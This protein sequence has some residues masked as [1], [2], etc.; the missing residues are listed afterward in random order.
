M[1]RSFLLPSLVT[2]IALSGTALAQIATSTALTVSPSAVAQGQSARLSATVTPLSG[3]T[4]TGSVSFY[5]GSILLASAPLSAGVASVTESAGTLPPGTYSI[6]AQY[7]GNSADAPSISAPVTAYVQ[8][9]TSTTVSAANSILIVGQLAQI[10][11]TVSSTAGTPTG[12]VNFF[13]GSTLIGSAALNGGSATYSGSTTGIDP[14]VYPVT[15]RY[16]GSNAFAP[17]SSTVDIT[18]DAAFTA[19]PANAAI[20]PGATQQFAIAPTVGGTITWAVNGLPGGNASY[21]TISNSGLYTAPATTS[22]LTVHITASLGSDPRYPAPS[23]PVYVIPAGV[24]TATSN[25]QVA[26]YTINAPAG[27]SV[28]VNFGTTTSYGLNTWSVP[29]P[30]DGG[31]VTV[32]VAGML[33]D[34]LYNIQGVVTLPDGATFTDANNPFTTGEAVDASRTVPFT[35]TTVSGQTPQPGI[36]LIDAQVL[37]YAVDLDGNTIWA[38]PFTG[39][40]T[41]DVVRPIKLQPNGDFLSHIGGNDPLNPGT[42]LPGTIDIIQE[43]DLVGNV[44]RQVSL[45]TLQANLSAAGYNITL[46]AMHHDLTVNPTTGHW[47][48]LSNTLQTF[49]SVDGETGPQTVEGDIILDVDPGNNFAIDWVWNA[50]DYLDVN[51]HPFMFPDWTHSNAIIY[52]PTDHQLVVSVRHQNWILKLDY[53]DGGGSG[54]VLW[55]LGYQGD[56]SLIGGTSPQDWQYAQHGPNFTGSTSAGNFGLGVMD[57]GDDRVVPENFTCP[58]ALIQNVCLYSRGIVYQIDENA[59]TATLTTAIQSP[60]YSYFGG[61]SQMLPNGHLEYDFCS[62]NVNGTDE[63]YIVEYTPGSNPQLV[64]SLLSTAQTDYR[65]FRIGSLYPGVSWSAAALKFQ[66]AHATHPNKK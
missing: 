5:S 30:S 27:S 20:S 53:Q 2:L 49:Q 15:A 63:G 26:S 14:G 16:A 22:A 3:S 24:V 39:T 46:G 58:V 34:T 23:V 50:F 35:P 66:A 6:Y 38:T 4:P 40:T 62:A 25:G 12:N 48:V 1:R 55:R 59:M 54:N 37:G 11:A 47:I 45:A 61:Y 64:Y 33:A 36:E 10:T 29:A 52:S 13:V 41:E 19:S 8:S 7:K 42:N 60:Y 44:V 56:F 32:L 31:P 18:L 21:G 57:N 51:R 65:A 43:T 28:S 9:G 17:S